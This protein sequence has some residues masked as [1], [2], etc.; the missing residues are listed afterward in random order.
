MPNVTTLAMS[1]AERAAYSGRMFLIGQGTVFAVLAILWGALVL[2]RLLIARD[3]KHAKQPPVAEKAAPVVQNTPQN[4]DALI[5]VITA[6]V[7]ATMAQEQGTEA[8]AFRVVSF[9]RL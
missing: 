2:F 3:K 9:R 7:A 4:D 8:P 6:A 1:F 5:A